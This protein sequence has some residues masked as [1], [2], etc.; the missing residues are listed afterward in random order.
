VGL[1][2]IHKKY[3]KKDPENI[4]KKSRKHYQK[5]QKKIQKKIPKTLP[6]DYR[7]STPCG[8]YQ[9]QTPAWRWTMGYPLLYTVE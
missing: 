2:K 5:I 9:S 4:A 3:C 8:Q 1:P 6:K 7:N